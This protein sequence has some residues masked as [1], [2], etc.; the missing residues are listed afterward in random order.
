MPKY[1]R[2]TACDIDFLSE[3]G[4]SEYLEDELSK[5]PPKYMEL[6]AVKLLFASL[7]SKSNLEQLKNNTKDVDWDKQ[8]PE[9]QAI[10]VGLKLYRYN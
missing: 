6:D 5:L 1:I 3:E 10:A 4:V 7:R 2:N 9:I 8:I